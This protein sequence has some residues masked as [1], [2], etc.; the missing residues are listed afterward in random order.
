VR[1][2]YSGYAGELAPE[3][4]LD[5]L[6]SDEPALLLDIRPDIARQKD[7]L[8]ELKRGARWAGR[9]GREGL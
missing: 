8:A 5:L 2:R 7:G 1:P 6:Y 9:E 4:V 3:A